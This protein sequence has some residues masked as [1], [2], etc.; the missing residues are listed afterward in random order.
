MKIQSGLPYFFFICSFIIL[1]VLIK[2]QEGNHCA[3]KKSPYRLSMD[4]G[5]KVYTLHCMS[6]HQPDGV[7]IPNV[8]PPLNC[9]QVTGDKNKLIN[10]IIKGSSA[11]QEINGIVYN[12]V[13]PPNSGLNDQEIADVL[14]YIRNSFGNKTSA[15]KVSEVKS[16][17]SNLK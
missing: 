10:I 15:V 8:N 2:A 1:P 14:T 3:V 13:M 9:Q 12:N 5:K 11:H 7:G 17:G 6:C 4:S 16:A